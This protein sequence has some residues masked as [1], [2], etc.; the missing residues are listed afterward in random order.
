[1]SIDK[2]IIE[3]EAAPP[4]PDTNIL[5]LTRT[6]Y[7]SRT[8]TTPTDGT[9]YTYSFW[10]KWNN[11]PAGSYDYM[12]LS[13]SIYASAPREE[14]HYDYSNTR[15]NLY[16]DGGASN[17]GTWYGP[18]ITPPTDGVWY[19][20]V[21]QKTA[22]QAPVLYINGTNIGTYTSSAAPSVPSGDGTTTRMNSSGILQNINGR[23]DSGASGIDGSIAYC[24]FVDGQ[25]RS[26]SEFVQASGAYTIPKNYTTTSW[27]NNGFQLLFGNSGA[28]GTDTSGNGNNFTTVP[29]AT[30]GTAQVYY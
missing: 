9:K 21:L 27:G 25:L 4:I 29:S 30:T 28:I 26:P 24:Q 17:Q 16:Y 6:D 13:S 2:K 22:Q 5:T 20:Y 1:M 3:T 8:M 14:I 15:W 11:I 12:W 19:H 23:S 18:T 10:Y 7:I